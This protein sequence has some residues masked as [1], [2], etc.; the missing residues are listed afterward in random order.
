MQMQM[1]MWIG[2]VLALLPLYPI[3]VLTSPSTILSLSLPYLSPSRWVV[4]VAL[5]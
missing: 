5:F 3:T 2:W 4:V 1:G